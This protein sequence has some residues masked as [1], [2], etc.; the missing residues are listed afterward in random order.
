MIYSI[1]TATRRQIL[2][3]LLMLSPNKDLMK[4]RKATCWRLP[5]HQ[6]QTAGLMPKLSVQLRP[7][8]S[9][10]PRMGGPPAGLRL[11]IKQTVG[12]LGRMGLILKDFPGKLNPMG[13]IFSA[14]LITTVTF[15]V[16][17]CNADKKL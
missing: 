9:A 15:R 2:A 14:F 3:L 11:L 12:M 4:Q 13:G 7:V 16:Q 5:I 10:H 6:T 17:E 8:K 1:L